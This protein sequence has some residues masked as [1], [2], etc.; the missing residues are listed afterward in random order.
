MRP[1]IALRGDYDAARL[2]ALPK[3]ARD[4]DQSRRLLVLGE[5]YEGGS[6]TKAARIVDVGLQTVRDWVVTFNARGP[7]AQS[8]NQYALMA[9]SSAVGGPGR[10][11]AAG[12]YRQTTMIFHV[13]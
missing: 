3:V 2:R 8:P 4:A 13:R 7:A 10:C 1:G 5:I 9:I 12:D 6:R 11:T